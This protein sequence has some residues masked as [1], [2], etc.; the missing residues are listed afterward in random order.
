MVLVGITTLRGQAVPVWNSYRTVQAPHARYRVSGRGLTSGDSAVAPSPAVSLSSLI[1]NPFGLTAFRTYLAG[2]FNVEHLEFYIAVEEF[3]NQ[4]ENGLDND[5]V[6]PT[7]NAKHMSV[8]PH[9]P[10]TTL[11]AAALALYRKF[12]QAGATYQVNLSAQTVR[13][14]ET[15]L[16]PWLPRRRNNNRLGAPFAR[17]SVNGSRRVTPQS[18][19]LRL[20]ALPIPPIQSGTTNI[21]LSPRNSNNVNTNTSATAPSIATAG[22]TSTLTTVTVIDNRTNNNTNTSDNSSNIV[23]PLLGP[24]S[25]G[26]PMSAIV[27]E[28]NISV[29]GHG[30]LSSQRPGTATLDGGPPSPAALSRGGTIAIPHTA[31]T[32]R[33]SLFNDAQQA[34]FHLLATDVFPR[35]LK[36]NI[37]FTFADEHAVALAHAPSTLD[38]TSLIDP[39]PRS[40]SPAFASAT[41][42]T[43]RHNRN[44]GSDTSNL[45]RFNSSSLSSPT[46][47]EPTNERSL[48]LQ[49]NLQ[50]RVTTLATTTQGS[51]VSGAVPSSSG[52]VNSN[53]SVGPPLFAT[54]SRTPI[55][56]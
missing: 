48:A 2:E 9:V 28:S 45:P 52:A 54:R 8:A 34:I 25:M 50:S 36:S 1:S 42:P 44:G 3:V 14:I 6:L 20:P 38:S 35:F 33:S 24:V 37:Y 10:I 4:A 17:I 23:T 29:I 32:V 22:A 46:N 11:V 7:G 21:R 16:Q 41:S 43:G 18:S 31:H 13:Q 26:G 49:R 12:I 19:R 55:T 5:V 56:T 53:G 30:H 15:E 51:G 39:Q 47:K 40:G 27:E